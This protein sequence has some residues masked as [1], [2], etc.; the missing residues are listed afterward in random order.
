MADFIGPIDAIVGTVEGASFSSPT[1]GPY[2]PAG[3]NEPAQTIITVAQNAP[4]AGSTQQQPT[5]DIAYVFDAV[6]RIEH[7]QSIRRTEHPVQ[8]GAAISD[9]AF[10]L[11]ARVVLE[12][13]MS[14]AMDSYYRDS[15]AGASTKSVSAYQ[16][17]LKLKKD[18]TLV[19]IHTRLDDYA[20]MIVEDIEAPDNKETTHGLRMIVTFSEFILAVATKTGGQMT[21][22]HLIEDPQS[23]RPQTT[24]ATGVGTIQPTSVPQAISAQHS[25]SAITEKNPLSQLLNLRQLS[26]ISRS[27]PG[28]GTWSSTVLTGIARDFPQL[29][30]VPD[31]D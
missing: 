3:W 17:M 30:K 6:L 2:R 9:H 10:D 16:T 18:K 19:N 4:M 7:R 15:W 27:V 20:N 22:W 25:I 14:D 31:A 1:T 13:K 29:K 23:S 8:S 21:E 26:V 24:D 12:I 5:E 11:P 28:A